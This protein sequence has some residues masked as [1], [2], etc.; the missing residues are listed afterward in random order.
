MEEVHKHLTDP[1]TYTRL[2]HDITNTVEITIQIKLDRLHKSGLLTNRQCKYC[3]PPETHRTSLIYFLIKLHKNP[4]T[5]RPI[6]S[7]TNSITTKLSSFLDYWLKQAT[8]HLL[9]DTT[10]LI[11]TLENKTFDRDI[12][13]CTVDVTNMYTNIPTEEG[14][15]TAL[16]ALKNL[17]TPIQR[18]D[19]PVLAELLDTKNNVFEFNG[20][21]YLQTRGVPMGNIM[22]PS[23]NGIF[24]GELEQKLIQLRQNQT[25]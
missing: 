3:Y 8:T 4:H 21:F 15:Q 17:K 10:Y 13:L 2:G 7:C 16:R 12:L 14:N 24:M 18:P 11:Q 1:E 20:E 23:Y 6:C 22:A 19:L 9:R 5:Y 25:G